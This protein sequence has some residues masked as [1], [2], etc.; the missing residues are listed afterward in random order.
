MFAALMA[1]SLGWA[2]SLSA[3]SSDFAPVCRVHGKPDPSADAGSGLRSWWVRNIPVAYPVP[4]FIAHETF[5]T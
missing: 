1:N 3:I 2:D 4:A 5:R